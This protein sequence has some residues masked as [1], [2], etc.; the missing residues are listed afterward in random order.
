MWRK[1]FQ[2]M[3][4]AGMTF[5]VIPHVG[6]QTS[7]TTQCA[8]GT[9]DI[10]FP[11]ASP[12]NS[13][14]YQQVGNLDHEKGTLGAA[15][16]AANIV[17]LQIHLG[18][19]FAPAE[20]GFPGQKNGTFA[21]WA[22]TQFEAASAL[23]S[24][25][26]NNGVGKLIGFYTEIEE[27]NA[28]YWVNNYPSF[29]TD[30]WN[31][32]GS[33]IK[34]NLS[35]K[36]LVWASPY[37]IGNKTRHP[38]GFVTPVEYKQAWSDIF[39]AAPHLDLVSPQDSMG[40]Q[41][42]SFENASDYLAAVAA[43]GIEAKR[44]LP[45][46]SNVELFE[47]WP[48]SCQFPSVCHGRHPASFTGRIRQQMEN[49]ANVLSPQDRGASATLIAWEWRSCF[50]PNNHGDPHIPFPNETKANYDDYLAY[51]AEKDA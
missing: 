3:K 8:N 47:V 33:S 35:S 38:T 26:G 43:A 10:Y 42:N 5:T 28:E 1:E 18:L 12:L 48:L 22:D 25:F 23:H 7:Y 32:L 30:Y 19:L 39:R 29:A 50:S 24:L 14:C 40:A 2:S 17:G 45:Q 20:H 34:M 44:S 6:K 27:S 51:L 16:E 15:F 37:S 13:N 36:Y 49:E 41:G 31:R 46:W 9:F 21:N 4:D 11:V